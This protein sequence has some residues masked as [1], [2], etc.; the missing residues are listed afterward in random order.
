[1]L[2]ASVNGREALMRFS[3]VCCLPNTIDFKSS[4][5]LEEIGIQHGPFEK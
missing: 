1:M 5:I 3:C 4:T 2:Y